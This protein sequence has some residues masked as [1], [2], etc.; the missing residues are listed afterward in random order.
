MASTRFMNEVESVHLLVENIARRVFGA[1]W[2]H[3]LRGIDTGQM[4]DPINSK[5]VVKVRSLSDL[6]LLHEAIVSSFGFNA[7]F[8]NQNTATGDTG[9][10]LITRS[11][12]SGIKNSDR[13]WGSNTDPWTGATPP[14]VRLVF[15]YTESRV[16]SPIL[17]ADLGAALNEAVATVISSAR[18][19][20]IL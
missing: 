10:W 3:V 7:E 9:N 6:E 14:G 18:G 15:N 1:D 12:S 16:A 11:W 4:K 5:V 19:T 20:Q 2:A 17:P 13:A 8:S